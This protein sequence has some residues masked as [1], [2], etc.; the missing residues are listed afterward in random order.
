MDHYEE[1][2]G[3]VKALRVHAERAKADSPRD[4]ERIESLARDG[5]E[6]IWKLLPEQRAAP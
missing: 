4:A 5:M 6:S 3:I 1:L 2:L